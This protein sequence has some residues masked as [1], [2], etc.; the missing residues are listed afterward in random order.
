VDDVREALTA[1]LC[2]LVGLP[3]DLLLATNS[4]R[5][6]FDFRSSPKGRAYLWIDPPWRLMVGGTLRVGSNDYPVQD[7]AEDAEAYPSLLAAWCAHFDGLDGAP[8]A[9]ACL[10]RDYPD[11]S[12]RFESG[13]RLETFSHG[14]PA[15]WWY[16][17]DCTTGEVFEAGAWGIRRRFD[18][19]A[20]A[21][22][23]AAAERPR[24]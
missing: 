10:G 11:L 7:G 22:P 17:K 24:D 14:G 8:L 9:E 4:I 5:L 15:C 19:P 12:L 21:E 6:R 1:A 2:S 23:G 18:S 13:H 16:Y 20:D 3:C